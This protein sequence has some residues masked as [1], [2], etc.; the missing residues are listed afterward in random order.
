MKTVRLAPILYVVLVVV[1]VAF[2][3]I[4]TTFPGPFSPGDLGPA[5]FPQAIAVL[6]LVLIVVEWMAARRTWRPVPLSDVGVGFAAGV[7]VAAAVVLAGIVGIYVVLPP[8]LF[9]A[10]WLLGERRIGL[11]LAYSIG[12]PLFLWAFF[13]YALGKPIGTFGT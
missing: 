3:A 11:V 2:Y 7:Y 4:A 5:L 8:V 1:A 10:L 13:A 9:A 6:M 12:F